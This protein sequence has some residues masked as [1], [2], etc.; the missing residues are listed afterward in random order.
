MAGVPRTPESPQALSVAQTLDA[1]DATL[2]GL[3]PSEASE[4]L[5]AIGPN[6]LPEGE[7]HTIFQMIVTSSRT[8]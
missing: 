6:E 4:R 3:D 2:D 5:E 7:K 8:S 1:V